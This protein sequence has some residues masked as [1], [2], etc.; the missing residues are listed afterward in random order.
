LRKNY[1]HLLPPHSVPDAEY[2][3]GTFEEYQTQD[4]FDLIS[5]TVYGP[6][7]PLTSQVLEKARSMLKK[8]GLI[9]CPI[10]KHKMSKIG[11]IKHMI[12]HIFVNKNLNFCNMRHGKKMFLENQL[13]IQAVISHEP[14]YCDIY[15]L[16][17]A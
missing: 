9:F 14:S 1:N 7:E 5:L 13:S 8:D 17:N 6:Y 12:K 4:K 16:K 15:I 11:K 10:V 3:C 2:F